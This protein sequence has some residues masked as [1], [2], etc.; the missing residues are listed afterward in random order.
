MK[1]PFIFI[2]NIE[3]S[4][5]SSKFATCFKNLSTISDKDSCETYFKERERER[6]SLS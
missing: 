3:N 2:G 6:E 1:F 4:I 5:K